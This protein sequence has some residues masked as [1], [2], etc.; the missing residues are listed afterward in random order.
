MLA[1]KLR[2]SAP[3]EAVAAGLMVSGTARRLAMSPTTR[4]HLENFWEL[5]DDILN[6]VLFLLLG[7]ELLVL[8]LD[9]SLL[10]AGLIA[11]PVVLFARFA[12]VTAVVRTLAVCRQRITGNVTV[13]TWGGLRGALAVALALSLPQGSGDERNLLLAATYVAVVFSILVQGLTISPL[14]RRLPDRSS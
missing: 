5:I 8:P 4:D 12:S 9:A 14:L 2:L 3:L 7:L 11:I 6:V 13:L 10:T 1:D